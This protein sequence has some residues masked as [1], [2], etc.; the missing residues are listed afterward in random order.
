MKKQLF[1]SAGL[2]FTL[3]VLAGSAN[4][5]V[6]FT[7]NGFSSTAGLTTTGTT[8]TTVTGDGTVLR[9]TAASSNQAGAAYTTVP[10]ALGSNDTFST[11]FQ[12]RFTNPGGVDPADGITFV[13]AANPNG[14][15]GTGVGLGYAGVTNSV[16]IE[17]DTYNNGNPNS[18]GFFSAEPDSS[19]HV[20]VDTNGL[21]TDTASANVYGNASCG[22][23]NGTPAQNPNTAPGCM[24]NGGLWTATISYDGA[25]LTVNLLDPAKGSTFT[26][27][28]ALPVNIASL[29]G[30]TSAFAGFTG[31]TGAGW[32]NQDIVNWTLSNTAAVQTT[33]TPEPF[34]TGLIASGLLGLAAW[35]RVRNAGKHV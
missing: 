23:A 28:N 17:F 30:T 33:T 19:N 29:L 15:G 7:Y 31:S 1:Y 20:A 32:E 25:A 14:L 3:A 27:I 34:S 26:A 11:Q 10:V 18:L 12:F 16:A 21:L 24:S 8:T 6:L 13:L 22:F 9:L 5:A 35:R 2:A 4:A